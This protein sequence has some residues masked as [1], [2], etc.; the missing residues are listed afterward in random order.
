MEIKKAPAIKIRFNKAP[1]HRTHPVSGVWGG[2]TPQGDI[3]CNFYIEHP[4]VPETMELEIDVPT[5]KTTEKLPEN[6][7]S[8][9][10]DILTSVVLRPDIALSIGR[11]LISKAEAVNKTR[12]IKTKNTTQTLQ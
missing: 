3:L 8:Y 1:D 12:Q 4:E 11:W 7:I 2:A 6:G 5:G 9:V 10:R